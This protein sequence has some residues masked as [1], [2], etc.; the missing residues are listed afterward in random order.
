MHFPF[1]N[2]SRPTH[3]FFQ[4]GWM[5]MTRANFIMYALLVAVF[6]LGFT[7]RLPG[8]KRQLTEWERSRT[9][10]ASRGHD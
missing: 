10:E 6:I 9:K 7:L 2:L 4:W 1:F 8:A 5:L 3:L